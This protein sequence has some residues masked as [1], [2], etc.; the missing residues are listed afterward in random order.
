M[1]QN[2]TDNEDIKDN[3]V[4][5]QL[6]IYIHIPFCVKKCD[7]CDFLS[8]PSD[9]E[10][11]QKYIEALITQIRS[12]AGRTKEYIVSTIFIGG[13]T[14][15]CIKAVYIQQI[16]QALN[17]V[18]Q[19]DTEQLEATIEVNPGTVTRQKLTA[20]KAAGINRISFGL[21]S[22]EDKELKL[23]GRIHDFN[24]FKDNYFAAREAGFTNINVDLMSALP[25]QTI[26]SW[27]ST[28]RRVIELKPEH[29][30]AYSLII[31]EGT[32]FFLRYKEGTVGE[33][34]LP[35]EEAD[36]LMY[37]ITKEI[38]KEND[39]HR[40][41]ISNY[42][43]KGYE[44]RHNS[45]YWTGIEYLGLGLGASS[46]V[47]DN[48]LY[49]RFRIIDDLRQYRTQCEKYQFEM[50]SE[51]KAKPSKENVSIED[52]SKDVL[53][54]QREE[55]VLTVKQRMEEF[56]FLGLR[57]S[58]GISKKNFFQRFH[59]GIDEIYKDILEKATLDKLLI[60][61]GDRIKLT[62]YG[63]DV[64]NTVLSEFLLPE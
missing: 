2:T 44:C 37:H 56:M 23:L 20:Y 50:R 42:A 17:E 30:S 24:Q 41:E 49:K 16:M 43:K 29:I 28:L 45:S 36:R 62:E 31:E 7:Y 1:E 64:S 3:L 39:Y 12:Y 54:L 6:G 10:T 32:P 25:G 26:T 63:V 11:K 8:A 58:K 55:E 38:L 59:V 57:L 61:E 19:I 4:L 13:G 9:E 52:L 5:R 15:S 18:F 51:Q 40:Y 33:S 60:I 34:L 48:S 35:G 27:E 22:T 46:Y 21:Q 53:G 47:L 14:P